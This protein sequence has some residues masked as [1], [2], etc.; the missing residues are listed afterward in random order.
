M[1]ETLRTL[2]GGRS[3]GTAPA[4]VDPMAMAAA[5]LLLYAAGVDGTLDEAE[6]QTVGRLIERRFGI[7]DA[8]IDRL[9]TS[10][11]ARAGTAT[12][13]YSLTRDIKNGLDEGERAQMIEML[14]EVV[15]ADGTADDYESSLVRRVAG[16]LYVSDVDSGAARKRVIDRLGIAEP[17][18]AGPAA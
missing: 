8:D 13:L 14:W 10:A 1:F 6:R 4:A 18:T 15:Y 5:A 7:A 3:V 17:A 11:D 12:D 9:I 16:L 2:L